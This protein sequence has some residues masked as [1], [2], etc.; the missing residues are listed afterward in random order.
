MT[1]EAF[2][3]TPICPR[4]GPSTVTPSKEH[5]IAEK[6]GRTLCVGYYR[7]HT[8]LKRFPWFMSPF[9]RLKSREEARVHRA[10][11]GG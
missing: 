11:A 4:C 3:M 7:C 1:E 10:S 2:D 6:I 9:M 8:C 5:G